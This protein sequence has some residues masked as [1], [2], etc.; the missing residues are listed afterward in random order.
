MR[1]PGTGANSQGV[2]MVTNVE[3]N[4]RPVTQQGMSGMK[5]AGQGPGRQVADKS[6][7]LNTLRVKIQEISTEMNKLQGEI[8]QKQREGNEYAHLQR[9][10]EAARRKAAERQ[11]TLQDYNFA[12][13]KG[14]MDMEDVQNEGK[15]L[16]EVCD[17]RRKEVDEI[18]KERKTKE[19]ESRDLNSQNEELRKQALARLEQHGPDKVELYKRLDAEARDSLQSVEQQRRQLTDLTL[20]VNANE[21]ELKQDPLRKKGA[22]LTADKKMYEEQ[23]RDL[24]EQEDDETLPFEEAKKRLLKKIT[25]DNVQIQD[26]D[27]QKASISNQIKEMKEKLHQLESNLEASKGGRSEKHKELQMKDQEMSKYLDAYPEE[28]KKNV[29][30]VLRAEKNVVTLLRHIS[31]EIGRTSALPSA[32]EVGQMNSDLA[33]KQ[34]QFENAESTLQR[35]QLE[36][37]ERKQD[38][39]RVE[40]LERKMNQEMDNLNQKMNEMRD[41]IKV[42][43]NLDALKS[44][45]EHEKKMYKARRK[46]LQKRRDALKVSLKVQVEDFEKKKKS[47]KESEQIGELEALEKKLRAMEDNLFVMKEFVA[48]KGAETDVAPHLNEVRGMVFEINTLLSQQLQKAA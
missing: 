17:F 15:R 40:E 46:T 16:Q 28:K 19:A 32:G 37:N 9:R 24:N 21:D 14:G 2:G 43:E 5:T 18:F 33:F 23:L 47:V 29:E 8:D 25:D 38:L 45:A 30:A 10:F 6:F 36:L 26:M 35:V 39:E 4:A 34:S 42:F 41:E 27:N 44:R 22:Q 48:E 3:I 7:F 31:S 20:A 11:T 1:P 12:K 13:E